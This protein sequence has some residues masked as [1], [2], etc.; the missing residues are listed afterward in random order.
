HLV[1]VL[2]TYTILASA[3]G[4]SRSSRTTGKK[5]KEK[6]TKSDHIALE[7]TSRVDFINA[8]LAI[9]D[10]TDQYQASLHS[11]PPV[12]IWWTGSSGGKSGASTIENNH[13]F[14]VT[15]TAILKKKKSCVVNI[16]IDLDTMDG[17]RVKKRALPTPAGTA[18]DE[19]ELRHGD[20]VPRLDTYGDTQQLHGHIILQLKS[21]WPCDRHPGEHGEQGYCYVD[22]A[23]QHLGL[24]TRKF[25]LW[26]ATIAAADCTKHAPPNT[27]DFDCLRD[28]RLNIV[29]PHGRSNVGALVGSDLVA[30]LAAAAIPLLTNQLAPLIASASS[31]PAA[32]APTVSA[33]MVPALS[34]S[35]IP[36]TELHACLVDLLVAKGVDLLDAE[37]ALSRLDLTPDIMNKVPVGRLCEVTGAVEGRVHKLQAFCEEWVGCVEVK[38]QLGL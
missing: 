23:G 38:H 35:P 4:G 7:S 21:M 34:P 10:L 19:E 5:V 20:K 17:Y 31:T 3:P 25:A 32:H 8:A 13:D 1:T 26:S 30:L 16:E 28:G 12:K 37:P 24:N 18:D 15:R 6:I 29:K 11:G 27:V 36:G 2:I 14:E 22:T 9:H 33:P